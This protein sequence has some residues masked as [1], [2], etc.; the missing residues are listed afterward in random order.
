MPWVVLVAATAALAAGLAV[1]GLPAAPLFAGLLM[2]LAAAVVRV[3]GLR[4]R[5]V[6]LRLPGVVR[7][8]GQAVVGVLS[9][10]L[11]QPQTLSGLAGDWPAVLAAVLATLAL[12]LLAGLAFGLHPGVDR[13]TASFALVAGGASGLTAMSEQLGADQRVVAVVQHLRVLFVVALMPGVTT[14]LVAAGEDGGAG[15]APGSAGLLVRDAPLA[16]DLALTVG[17]AVA[18]TA[19]ARWLRL[20]A[21]SLLGPMLLALAVSAAGW[22]AG[23]G[24]PDP[25]V[26]VAYAVIGLEVGLSFTRRSLR[27]VGRLLPTALGLVVAITAATAAVGVPLL[28]QAGASTLDAYLATTPGGLYAVVATAADVGADTTL[29]LAVQVLRLVVMLLLAPVLALV[30]SRWHPRSG[31]AGG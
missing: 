19:L 11:V 25:V 4:R 18:G 28:R 2:G 3:P 16:A 13:V 1:L 31:G 29:V 27:L 9:G 22:T 23:A 20:P 14:L 8:A 12:S 26:Q 21:G 10:A 6:R 17:C 30:L 15:G 5:E 24:V 7:T